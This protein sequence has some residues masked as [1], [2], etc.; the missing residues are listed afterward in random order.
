[1]DALHTL[2]TLQVALEIIVDAAVIGLIVMIGR[3]I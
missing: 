2:L 3:R 1:M